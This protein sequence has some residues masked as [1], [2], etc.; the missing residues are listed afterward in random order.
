MDFIGVLEIRTLFFSAWMSGNVN[1]LSSQGLYCL[2]KDVKG[3]LCSIPVH[4]YVIITLY[5]HFGELV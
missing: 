2:L 1:Y 3:I 5:S 4:L